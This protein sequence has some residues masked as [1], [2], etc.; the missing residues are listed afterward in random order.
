M[1]CKTVL[2]K[3]AFLK[4]H[5]MTTANPNKIPIIIKIIQ[6]HQK[7]MS[8]KYVFITK[9]IF[10]AVLAENIS[11]YITHNISLNITYYYV[12]HGRV[13]LFFANNSL[14]QCRITMKFLH[15]FFLNHEV[16]FSSHTMF[17]DTSTKEF[18]LVNNA[19][20]SPGIAI[21]HNF[22]TTRWLPMFTKN[23][24][25]FF[26]NKTYFILICQSYPFTLVQLMFSQ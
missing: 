15:N 10:N 4:I 3:I 25:I 14:M 23:S 11:N 22:Y 9:T 5:I 1:L 8:N 16:F 17:I 2:N 18:T 6:Y 20:S 13:T 12:F 26:K 19:I 21:E 24:I 7:S